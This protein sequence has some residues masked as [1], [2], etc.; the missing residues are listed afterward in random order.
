[1][2]GVLQKPARLDG[3]VLRQR[4]EEQPG[5][6]VRRHVV[7]EE[8]FVVDGCGKE[9]MSELSAHS[10]ISRSQRPRR[11]LAIA[12]KRLHQ[13]DKAGRFFLRESGRDI[14][15]LDATS[16]NLLVDRVAGRLRAVVER[17]VRIVAGRVETG[18]D[19]VHQRGGEGEA[20][21]R[22]CE[23]DRARSLSQ[24][25]IAQHAVRLASKQSATHELAKAG[26]VVEEHARDDQVVRL[27]LAVRRV[28]ILRLGE[29]TL[30]HV[31]SEED[32]S[33][34]RSHQHRR[35]KQRD[36]ANTHCFCVD[37]SSMTASSTSVGIFS[38]LPATFARSPSGLAF[39]TLISPKAQSF[40]V[41]SALKASALPEPHR[42]RRSS[43][44]VGCSKR[45]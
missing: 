16:K 26:H 30:A 41:F 5:V 1:M 36:T 21:E 2:K 14:E 12:P 11:T 42:F 25:Q 4:A 43:A 34:A 7:L 22:V 19:K 8:G 40:E 18:L 27:E 6:G 15:T 38:S 17:R 28:D 24:V 37:N 29:Q 33:P 13:L 23:Y 32:G 35:I 44:R 31:R 20:C 39:P 45:A 3:Q 9:R 10:S